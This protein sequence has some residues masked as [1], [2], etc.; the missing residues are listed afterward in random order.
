MNKKALFITLWSLLGIFL[1]L[2]G[3]DI[4]LLIPEFNFENIMISARSQ[5]LFVYIII[6]SYSWIRGWIFGLQNRFTVPSFLISSLQRI[7]GWLRRSLAASLILLPAILL[8]F[9]PLA[10]EKI[11]MWLKVVTILSAALGV[12]FLIRP[13]AILADRLYTYLFSILMVGA[14]FLA[15]G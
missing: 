10:Y 6:A 4:F 11:G 7:P 2:I 8:F 12:S 13:Q 1:F 15:G 9:T 5:L 14:V 3:R